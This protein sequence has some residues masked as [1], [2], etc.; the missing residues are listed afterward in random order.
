MATKTKRVPKSKDEL[1]AQMAH[2]QKVEH[3][4][5]L[6]RRIY[7]LIEDQKTI[8][9]AQTVLN[10][11]AGYIKN[12]LARKSTS[13]TVAELSVDASKDKGDKALVKA[14][15]NIIE[16]LQGEKA[17]DSVALLERF[18]NGVAQYS[19]GK[20][21]ENPMKVIGIEDLIA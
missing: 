4:K 16:L 11:A 3:Q 20:Y 14:V 12:E 18:A 15:Q 5:K 8:Y 7:P 9:D 6:A 13:F 2:L 21:M 17:D 19:S 10:A 1:K